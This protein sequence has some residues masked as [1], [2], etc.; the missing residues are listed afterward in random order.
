MTREFV[1]LPEF[2]KQCKQ[3]SLTEDDVILI[4]YA[5]LE[6]PAIG[7]IMQG[8]GGIRMFRYALPDTGKSGGA[9]VIFVDYAYYEKVYLLTVFPK[10]EKEN[11]TKAERNDLKDLGN[12]LLSE[13]RKQ[14]RK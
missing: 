3:M 4:E 11:L 14:A 13:L 12:I 7:N 9:R 1:R 2:E 10:D 8:T 6:N 5:I